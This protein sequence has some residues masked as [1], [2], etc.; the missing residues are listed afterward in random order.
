MMM[1]SVVISTYYAFSGL[2]HFTVTVG[3]SKSSFINSPRSSLEYFF[4]IS[5]LSY[6]D[7]ET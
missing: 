4:K 6:V 3:V 2:P 1:V 7:I 5:L